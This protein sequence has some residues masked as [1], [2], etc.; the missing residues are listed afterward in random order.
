MKIDSDSFTTSVVVKIGPGET[1][2]VR[3]ALEWGKVERREPGEDDDPLIKAWSR[4]GSSTGS[5]FTTVGFPLEV[6][7]ETRLALIDAM[8]DAKENWG[9]QVAPRALRKRECEDAITIVTYAMVLI[10]TMALIRT[11]EPNTVAVALDG[12]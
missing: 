6:L 12:E 7:E 2:S 11:G 4:H 8:E 1:A 3:S 5:A 9:T 10:R